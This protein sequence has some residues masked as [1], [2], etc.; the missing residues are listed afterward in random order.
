MNV[1]S[2]IRR[3]DRGSLIELLSCLFA[4]G[5]HSEI[6]TDKFGL[7]PHRGDKALTQA[8][9]NRTQVCCMFQTV[10]FVDLK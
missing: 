1:R 2:E 4:F 9:A 8:R 6:K 5:T 7:S 10:L 3:L